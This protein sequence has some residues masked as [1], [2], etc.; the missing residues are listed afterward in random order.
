[1]TYY[2]EWNMIKI[3]SSLVWT[4]SRE[5]IRFS[6]DLA[7]SVKRNPEV[8]TWVR[9]IWY[10]KLTVDRI[11]Q[12]G[13]ILLFHTRTGVAWQSSAN[14]PAHCPPWWSLGLA[15]YHGLLSV[16]IHGRVSWPIVRVDTRTN[17]NEIRLSTLS[18]FYR[19]KLNIMWMDGFKPFLLMTGT[20]QL[21]LLV[22]EAFIKKK[23]TKHRENSIY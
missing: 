19:E 6:L 10:C 17:S 23:T 12:P 11:L 18:S 3:S 9:S 22:R 14:F 13:R 15:G 8:L 20:L 4:L 7:K 2:L 16:L 1:M 5:N 21:P